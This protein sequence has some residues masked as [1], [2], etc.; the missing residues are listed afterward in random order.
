MN[1]EDK[2]DIEERVVLQREEAAFAKEYSDHQVGPAI[3]VRVLICNSLFI[4]L[5]RHL[6]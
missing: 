3:V 2:K 1:K 4:Y 5:T 6:D